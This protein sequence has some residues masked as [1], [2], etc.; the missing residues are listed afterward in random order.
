MKINLQLI[1]AAL[2]LTMGLNAQETTIK[3]RG[4]GTPQPSAEWNAW[5]NKKV[6]EYK[7]NMVAGKATMI[8][9]NI[10]VIV[11]VIH[12]GQAV[13]TYPNLSQAQINSQINILNQDFSGTGLNVNQ[14][15]STGFST[16]GA[17]QTGLAFCPAT[18]TPGGTT[19]TEPG[20]ERIN[21]NTNSWQDPASFSSPGAFQN[22]INTVV[23]PAT[24]WDPTRYLNIWVTDENPSVGL[25][26][27]AVFPGGAGLSGLS[28]P[29]GTASDDGVWCLAG[30]YGN[31]GS[32]VPG[33]DKGRTASHEIGHWLGLLHIGGDG[34]GNSGGDCA[35]SDFCND[36]P[37]QKGGFA[38]GQFGQNYGAP[39]YPIHVGVCSGSS[40]GDMFMNFMD[41]TDD[42]A[43]YMFT[44]DQ[45]ARFQTAMQN[46]TFRTQLSTSASTMCVMTGVDNNQMSDNNVTLYPNPTSGKVSIKA[47]FST[48][49]SI[50][51]QVHNAL[52]QLI[53]SSK[54]EGV[55][56]DVMTI[57]LTN[58]PEG[59][60]FITLDNGSSRTV[61]RLVISK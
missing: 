41:Y 37:P 47:S 60:Y 1:A 8:A 27:F 12:G 33:F 35:A 52:G 45:S 28:G 9:Y 22:F 38:S 19:L 53:K 16:T 58:C 21:Y 42:A 11:H 55:R 51:I 4:C 48:N 57:D 39:T 40:F 10:P 7:A 18:K 36:T 17:A 6:D 31:V 15:A 56:N 29:F 32:L 43:M 30:A 34:N 44:P 25:L 14:L 5:F 46:G 26:G 59:V 3:H 49:N 54:H 61:K 23:K 20:I 2:T 13:G 24:I 50:D